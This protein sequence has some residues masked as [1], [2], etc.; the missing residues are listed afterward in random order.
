VRSKGRPAAAG[1]LDGLAIGQGGDKVADDAGLGRQ[2]RVAVPGAPRLEQAGVAFQ[3]A[4][5]VG[6]VAVGGDFGVAA[7]GAG[8]GVVVGCGGQAGRH[9]LRRS[10]KFGV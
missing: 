3:G 1:N 9:G 4:L 7:Q 5:G 8:D 2:I 10:W 6:G